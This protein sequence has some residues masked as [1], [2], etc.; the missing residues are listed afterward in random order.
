MLIGEKVMAPIPVWF[1]QKYDETIEKV[2]NTITV[3][4]NNKDKK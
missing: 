3:F 1:A 4:R 2:K